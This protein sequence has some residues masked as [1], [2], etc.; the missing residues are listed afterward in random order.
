[1]IRNSV[2]FPPPTVT[3]LSPPLAP[4]A[5][6]DELEEFDEENA[7]DDPPQAARSSPT[8]PIA[9]TAP[10]R[11]RPRRA[12]LGVLRSGLALMSGRLLCPVLSHAC[13]VG[14]CAT[15]P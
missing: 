13:P 2:K 8:A 15:A 14:W 1:M 6:P 3:F 4:A 5:A 10:S 12:G 9:A 7:S 11:R